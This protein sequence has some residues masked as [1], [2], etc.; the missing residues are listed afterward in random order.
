MSQTAAAPAAAAAG[1]DRA[2]GRPFIR[3]SGVTKTFSGFVA[4]NDLTL[5]VRE[6]EIFCLLGG[7]GSGKSTLLRML[8]GFETPDRG[9]IEIDGQDMTGVPPWAR[10]VNMMFQSYALFPHMSVA[11][12][13][14]YGLR[15]DGVPRAER[16]ERVARMLELVKLTPFA[17][18]KPA[19]LSGG[20]RQR[21]A[22]ARALVKRPKALLLDE[23]LSALDKKLREETQFELL[24]IQEKLGTTFIV[25]THDQ[26]EAMTLGDRIGVMD[27]GELIQVD[28][29][30]DLYEYPRNRFIAEFV[31]SVN[32]FEGR[33]VEDEADHVLLGDT[34]LGAE[35]FI[36]HGLSCQMG[37]TLWVAVRPEKM[38]L[39]AARPDDARNA[40]QGVIEDIAYLGGLTHYRVRLD[41]GKTVR[42]TRANVERR[43]ADGLT[44]NDRAWISW[45]PE[46]GVALTS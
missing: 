10:P 16:A 37:Q 36:H 20:Q 14:E 24:D 6:G 30:R 40:A 23:P 9:R 41:G 25:V 26:E 35:I 43:H 5:E 4:V 34:D 12:N 8:A 46:A 15:Q 19:Q 22:L 18:R 27:A 17:D 45:P 29:P 39:T 44:W 42:V 38:R 2:D 33:V 13:V 21:V 1:R 7:S 32:I 3:I 11:R 28:A 31:G